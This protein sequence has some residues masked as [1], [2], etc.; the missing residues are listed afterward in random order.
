MIKANFNTYASYVTDSLYQW[1][2][3][4]VLTVSGLN[5]SVAPEIHF[6]NSNMDRAIVRQATLDK[7]IVSVNIPNSLLQE[8]L[9]IKAHIGI[10]EGDTFK[11]IELV[12]I[13]VIPK[14][15]PSDYKIENTDEEI[16][17]F[18]ALKNDIANMVTLKDYNANNS[19][20]SIAISSL[21]SELKARID[22]IIAHNND[23]EG[24]T[25]LVDIRLGSD[26]TTYASAGEAVRTQFNNLKNGDLNANTLIGSKLSNGLIA[27]I[28]E[29]DNNIQ[30]PCVKGSIV[31]QTGEDTDADNRVRTDFIKVF[32]GETIRLIDYSN[33][34]YR[35]FLYNATD[36]VYIQCT[37][38][39]TTSYTF[40]D[41]YFVKVVVAYS[42]D[43]VIADENIYNIRDLVKI[44]NEFSRFSNKLLKSE[45]L[46]NEDQC[47]KRLK[48]TQSILVGGN[49]LLDVDYNTK[50]ISINS[51]TRLFFDN[52]LYKPN[53]LGCVFDVSD[54]V[55][56]SYIALCFNISTNDFE[57]YYINVDV[58]IP[59]ECIL[60]CIIHPTQPQILGLDIE[61]CTINGEN[62]KPEYIPG[63]ENDILNL[64]SNVSNIESGLDRA[65]NNQYYILD[66]LRGVYNRPDGLESG[67]SD[68]SLPLVDSKYTDLYAIYDDL[69]T[70][71]PDYVTKTL[72]GTETTGLPIYQYT[73]NNDIR[74]NY[75]RNIKKPKL[76][77]QSGIHGDEKSSTWAMAQFLK[78]LCYNNVDNDILSYIYWNVE[79]IVIP[80]ANPWG[81]NENSRF[82]A[83]GVSI[84]STFNGD[85]IQPETELI[86]A[87]VNANLD[88]DY[89]IDYHNIANG[90]T[91]GYIQSNDDYSA[92]LYCNTV[93]TLAKKWK[94]E[95]SLSESIEQFG[96]VGEV[97][98][99]DIVYYAK[100]KG[101][102]SFCL[103]LG[104]KPFFA[105]EKYDKT[106]I[107]IGTDLIGNVIVNILKSLT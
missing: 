36:K 3:N 54:N 11:V 6:S 72:L 27:S 41:D 81:W 46:N 58:G 75:E 59:K 99:Y 64:K 29:G 60:L 42:D 101:L 21:D 17:S 38:Y 26:N 50:K 84:G 16:Y 105:N 85:N 28:T 23:T 92:T 8:A 70:N 68:G 103:E 33:N 22:N 63:M 45:I 96:T 53:N 69:V 93:K 44:P 51:T 24:N 47:I 20:I 57:K 49:P 9:T 78:D 94:N 14:K 31:V 7:L 18:E 61:N 82:N 100:L 13:P 80:C 73:F 66:D 71:Y 88:V 12:E 106:C 67:A 76:L 5:L 10:Y 32:T 35:L 2:I 34:K 77:L 98:V 89:V 48:T 79:L 87:V 91:Y 37:E 52:I 40:N 55:N 107:D 97:T 86:Q 19:N 83:N 95:Y 1:D 102:K 74:F 39:L 56:M 65:L 43:S 90:V 30:V 25:E 4:Q 62:Y 15:R 104:W